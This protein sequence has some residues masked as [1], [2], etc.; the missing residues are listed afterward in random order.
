MSLPLLKSH[1]YSHQYKHHWIFLAKLLIIHINS[2]WG[3]FFSHFLFCF[4]AWFNLRYC[5]SSM[6]EAPFPLSVCPVP[7]NPPSVPAITQFML[8]HLTA[9]WSG[10]D[11]G[12]KRLTRMWDEGT[13]R[14]AERL[15]MSRQT[16]ILLINQNLVLTV[17]PSLGLCQ[18]PQRWLPALQLSCEEPASL[19]LPL[20]HWVARRTRRVAVVGGGAGAD[21]IWSM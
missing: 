3:V 8:W 19:Q 2:P 1:S 4:C 10:N 14:S 6:N 7:L 11:G 18:P 21:D 9:Y 16:S 12:I 5:R 15:Q 17:E 20:S 13:W